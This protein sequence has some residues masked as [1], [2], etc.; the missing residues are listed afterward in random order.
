MK[1]AGS[2]RRCAANLLLSGG[3]L[4]AALSTQSQPAPPNAAAAPANWTAAQDHQN[5]MEQLGITALRPGPSGKAGAPNEANYDE[6][7]ANPFPELP[8]PLTLKNGQKVT[9][10]QAW[11]NQRRPEIIEDFEREVFGRIP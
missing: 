1:T 3:L 2:I 6:S 4:C 9:S 5:M 10:A 8:D 7:K 11:W